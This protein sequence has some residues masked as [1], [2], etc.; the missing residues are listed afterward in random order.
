MA[1]KI[2]CKDAGVPN[3][4]FQVIAE[5]EDE[6]MKVAGTHA[7]TAHKMKMTP[8]L[9]AKVKKIVKKV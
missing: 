8:D 2:T 6:A 5:T 9:I 3:C 7:E 4:P 1:Y